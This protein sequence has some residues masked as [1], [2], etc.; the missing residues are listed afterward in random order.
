MIQNFNNLKIVANYTCT[1]IRSKIELPLV[2]CIFIIVGRSG[3]SER[4]ENYD[5]SQSIV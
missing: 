1:N 2:R 4:S 5:S 3:I